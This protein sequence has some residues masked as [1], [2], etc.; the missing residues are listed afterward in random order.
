MPRKEYRPTEKG[1]SS[2]ASSDI[3]EAPEPDSHDTITLDDW[4]DWLGPG[5]STPAFVGP[6]SD[7]DTDAD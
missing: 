3:A 1:Q 2:S 6:A 4:D 7:S 5:T